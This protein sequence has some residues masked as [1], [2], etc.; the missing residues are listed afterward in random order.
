AGG[1]RRAGRPARPV[2]AGP[3][4]GQ[5]AAPAGHAGSTRR[6]RPAGSR[7]PPVRP[8]PAAVGWPAAAGGHC[9]R[10]VS[11][12]D[13]ASGRRA[14]LGHGPGAGRPYP[15]GALPPCRKSRR[16]SGRQPACGGTGTGALSPDHR[17][18]RRADCFRPACGRSRHQAARRPLCQRAAG[19]SSPA[20]GRSAPAAP[21]RLQRDSRDPAALPRLLLTAVAV[22]LLWPGIQLAELDLAVLLA[23]DSQ[24][25]MG[26]FVS[27]FWPPAHSPDFLRLLFDATLQTLA[28][29]TAGMALALV[30]AIPTGL[31]ASRALSLSAVSRG[32]RPAALGQ[33]PRWQVRALLV[34]LVSVSERVW[35][36]LFAR[37]V[38][39][40]HTAGVRAI[41]ARYAG[42]L[43]KLYA[44]SVESVDRRQ[45]HHLMQ[46]GDGRLSAFWAGILT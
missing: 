16:H 3:Q 40:R 32:G 7:R 41:A 10:A 15:A 39:L 24:S 37:A 5:P 9:P 33:A 42:M 31:L 44:E 14:R 35:P 25:E 45:I 46:A 8:V 2:G 13:T 23:A 27:A 21:P 20:P 43:G 6:T 36:R 18:A 22:V 34:F 17:R 19:V 12:P 30:V 28:I 11:G 38:G 26:R 29:A 4:S 1:H